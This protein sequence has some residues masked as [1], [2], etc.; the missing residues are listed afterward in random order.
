LGHGSHFFLGSLPLGDI[1]D[2]THEDLSISL[3]GFGHGQLDG[4]SGGGV[5]RLDDALV[6]NADDA[7]DRGLQKRMQPGLAD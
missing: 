2:D 4:E 5:D 7:I 1:A 3:P 6:V